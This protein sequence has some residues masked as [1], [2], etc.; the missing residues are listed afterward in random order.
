M[1]GG[2]VSVVVGIGFLGQ[3]WLEPRYSMQDISSFARSVAADG[4]PIPDLCFVL[5]CSCVPML[6][7]ACVALACSVYICTFDLTP[8]EGRA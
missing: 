2:K 8:A 4:M 1:V 7:K 5:M 6:R 3:G